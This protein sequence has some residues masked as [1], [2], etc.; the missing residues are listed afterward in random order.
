MR[1]KFLIKLGEIPPGGIFTPNFLLMKL[2]PDLRLDRRSCVSMKSDIS[3]LV[4]P[5][6]KCSGSCDDSFEFVTGLK[7]YIVERMIDGC[8]YPGPDL[9]K[10]ILA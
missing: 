7:G 4:S 9:I 8:S 6:V 3:C 2:A 5:L 10:K 1:G